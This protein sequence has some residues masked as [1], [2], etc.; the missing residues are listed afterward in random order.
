M[1]AESSTSSVSSG[2][3][4]ILPTPKVNSNASPL[5]PRRPAE[6]ARLSPRR[7]N[8]SGRDTNDDTPSMGSSFSDL[9]GI[10]PPFDC[11]PYF[12]TDMAELQTQVLRNLR[13]KRL[14]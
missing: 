10:F 4:V 2:A 6:L 14:T 1:T 7:S 8:A 13:L 9:D 12:F 5:S 3:P 11:R